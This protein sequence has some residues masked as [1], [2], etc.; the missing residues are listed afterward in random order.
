MPIR[1]SPRA[2]EDLS[3]IIGVGPLVLLELAFIGSE[4]C[5]IRCERASY[6]ECSE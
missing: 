1:N 3:D 5:G 4:D 6:S 2:I